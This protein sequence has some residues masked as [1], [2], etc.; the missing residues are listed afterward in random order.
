V[1]I[2]PE[3]INNVDWAESTVYVDLTQS[4]I[5]NSPRYDS[6]QP[7]ENEREAVMRTHYGRAAY[8]PA[9]SKRVKTE[10]RV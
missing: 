1:I 5:K 4:A 10:A 9:E 8:S 6:T 7:L 3:W 2:A